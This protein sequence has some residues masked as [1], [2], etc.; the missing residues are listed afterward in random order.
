[1]LRVKLSSI[2]NPYLKIEYYKCEMIDQQKEIDLG[3]KWYNMKFDIS[4]RLMMKVGMQEVIIPEEISKQLV[5]YINE[6]IDYESDCFD[7]MKRINGE[8]KKRY[9]IKN[10]LEERDR[11]SRVTFGIDGYLI[12]DSLY[13]GRYESK[14]LFLNKLGYLGIYVNDYEQIQRMY[15]IDKKLVMMKSL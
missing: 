15:G 14:E 8:D 11:F 10:V 5:G 13:V 12:H 1:M 6:D 9:V 4:R 7:F 3:K 2:T